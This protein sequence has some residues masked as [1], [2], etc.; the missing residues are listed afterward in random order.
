ML[1][2]SCT[3]CPYIGQ[4]PKIL[5]SRMER[6]P[7][8]TS[9]GRLSGDQGERV[10]NQ[11]YEPAILPPFMGP[12]VWCGRAVGSSAR[13]TSCIGAWQETCW[14]QCGVFFLGCFGGMS[15]HAPGRSSW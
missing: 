8:P 9:I 11:V 15:L 3:H 5:H 4:P 12:S 10:W 2:E 13:A 14:H 7:M 1:A 6:K